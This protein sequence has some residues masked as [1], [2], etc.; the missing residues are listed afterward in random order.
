MS[1]YHSY[2]LNSNVNKKTIG[3]S[4]EDTQLANQLATQAFTM[5]C[6][7]VHVQTS[8]RIGDS[9]LIVGAGSKYPIKVHFHGVSIQPKQTVTFVM[10]P[11]F[12]SNSNY[13]HSSNY[14]PSNTFNSYGVAFKQ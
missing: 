6:N 9:V 5:N 1:I 14:L 10:A 3:F 13:S 4:S 2:G 12:K 8:H 7:E 11:V